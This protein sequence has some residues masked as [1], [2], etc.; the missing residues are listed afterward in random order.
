M[1]R[2]A[3]ERVL[4]YYNETDTALLGWIAESGLK[5]IIHCYAY[6]LLGNE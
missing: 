2:V 6:E 1:K 5:E 3:L 4:S